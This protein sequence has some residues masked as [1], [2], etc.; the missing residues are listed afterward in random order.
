MNVNKN[1]KHGWPQRPDTFPDLM[2]PIEAAMYLRLDEL[3]QTPK[4]ARRNLN[5]W[6]ERG[7]LRATKFARH[8]WF[9]KKELEIFMQNKTESREYST[10]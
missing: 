3:G 5:Y 1:K 8:L 4:Q 10:I 6:R 2:T 7:D 9:L